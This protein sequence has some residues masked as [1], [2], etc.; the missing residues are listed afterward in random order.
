MDR[1]LTPEFA[2]S[3]HLSFNPIKRRHQVDAIL[4]DPNMVG[5]DV[6][7]PQ[8]SKVIANVTSEAPVEIEFREPFSPILGRTALKKVAKI[9]DYLDDSKQMRKEGY[10]L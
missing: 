3:V 9:L 5:E 1:Q 6:I 10:L 2:E 8:N 7:V 4:H